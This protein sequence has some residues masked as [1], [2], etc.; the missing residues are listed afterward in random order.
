MGHKGP[1]FLAYPNF[2]VYLKWNK[3]LVYCNTAAYLAT[4]LAGAKKVSPGSNPSALEIGQVK[5]LQKKLR[6]R[7]HDVGKIDGIIG[8]GTRAAVRA[9]QQ[10][11]GLPADAWPDAALLNKLR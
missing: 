2:G 3:S 6:A 8:A 9:E 1:A 11:L 7:G 4:R 10:R 5:A